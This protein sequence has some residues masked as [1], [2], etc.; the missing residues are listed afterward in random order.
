[1]AIEWRRSPSGRESYRR[2]WER[3]RNT[4]KYRAKVRRNSA[5]RRANPDHADYVRI[6]GWQR[7]YG[8]TLDQYH[9]LFESQN[10][11]CAICRRIPKRFHVDHDHKTGRVRGLL[12][13]FCNRLLGQAHDS[14]SVLQ[15]AI[16]YLERSACH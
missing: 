8:L 5:K 2:A 12:C 13:D 6:Y 16:R 3:Y 11:H 9:A 7:H 4:E 14:V 1:M 15:S 10:E